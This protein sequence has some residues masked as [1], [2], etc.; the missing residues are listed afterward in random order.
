MYILR[1]CLDICLFTLLCISSSEAE[2]F[3][4][5]LASFYVTVSKIQ[6]IDTNL[7]VKRLGLA[8]EEEV[9]SIKR[10]VKAVFS[11]ALFSK[12]FARAL[13]LRSGV[14]MYLAASGPMQASFLGLFSTEGGGRGGGFS[15]LPECK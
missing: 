11:E 5:A 7:A 12:T 13:P 6:V 14:C 8:E 1:C 9:K 4:S 3:L 15:S 10:L 2:R